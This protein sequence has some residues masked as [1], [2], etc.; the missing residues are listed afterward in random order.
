MVWFAFCIIYVLHIDIMMLKKECDAVETILII[1]DEETISRVLAAYFKKE[2][3]HI[4]QAY[5]GEEGIQRFQDLSPSLV[6]LDIMLPKRNGKEILTSIRQT[7]DCPVIMLTALGEVDDRLNGLNNGADDYITKPF[8]GEEVVARAKA[9][10]RRYHQDDRANETKQFGSLVVN[11]QAHTVTLNG[12]ALS[13]TP[14]DLALLLFF[15]KH[16]NQTFT[17]EQLLDQVWGIDYTGSDRA[18]D[19]AVKRL[20]KVLSYWPSDEG[21]IKTIRGLGYQLSVYKQ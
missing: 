3:Y 5:D 20:R 19:L 1:E 11:E 15:A 6:I 8:I 2:G 21:E 14:R 10:L 4:I 13:L 12:I 16:P 18:V 17:R 7:S 9:V